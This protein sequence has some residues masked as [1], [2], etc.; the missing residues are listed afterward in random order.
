MKGFPKEKNETDYLLTFNREVKEWRVN[1]I[2]ELETKL[3][4]LEGMEK[5]IIPAS[6]LMNLIEEFLEALK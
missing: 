1:R 3:R 4:L 5:T 6:S 2:K